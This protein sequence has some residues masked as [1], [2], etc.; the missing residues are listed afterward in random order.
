MS[1]SEA[2]EER[3]LEQ[4]PH[5]P[6]CS[7]RSCGALLVSRST[8]RKWPTETA[9]LQLV[10]KRVDGV[11]YCEVCSSIGRDWRCK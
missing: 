5:L 1:F 11:P 3:L 6:L 2:Q 7:C 9:G 4:C 10:F 8:Q